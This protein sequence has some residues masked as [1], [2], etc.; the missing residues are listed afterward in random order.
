MNSYALREENLGLVA[1]F[2]R[3]IPYDGSYDGSNDESMSSV[4]A[5]CVRVLYPE[6]V[7]GGG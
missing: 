7:H 6:T 5:Q 2:L 1:V 4:R 3:I